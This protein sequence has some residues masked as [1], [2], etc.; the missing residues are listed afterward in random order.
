M[1]KW[2][3]VEK[4][5]SINQK[6]CIK[7]MDNILMRFGLPLVLVSDNGPQFV[8]SDFESYLKEREIKHKKSFVAYLQG[9]WSSGGNKLDYAKR[10]RKE[11]QRKKEQMA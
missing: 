4:M 6:D 7:F 9:Q 10:N 3:K 8:S 2:A 1:K 11:A 5:R